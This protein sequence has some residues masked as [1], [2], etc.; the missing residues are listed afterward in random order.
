[1]EGSSHC[2]AHSHACL[3]HQGVTTTIMSGCTSNVSAA[4]VSG[5]CETLVPYLE[6][7]AQLLHCITPLLG[8][9]DCIVPRAQVVGNL[10]CLVSTNLLGGSLWGKGSASACEC[11]LEQPCTFTNTWTPVDA[12]YAQGVHHATAEVCTYTW[13]L[14]H[15]P[16]TALPPCQSS[17]Q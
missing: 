8:P 14:A 17:A 1:V 5:W 12:A 16:R 6:A 4:S 2:Q 3:H 7:L 15:A 10:D 13:L 11:R 9:A